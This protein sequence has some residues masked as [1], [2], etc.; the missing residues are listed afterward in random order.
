MSDILGLNNKY[1]DALRTWLEPLMPISAR[2]Y[3]CYRAT[4]HGFEMEKFHTKC[5]TN[6]ET[7][8]PTV[9]LVRVGRFVFGGFSDQRWAG[10]YSPLLHERGRVLPYITYS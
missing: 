2:W 6:S 1:H 10:M 9:T 8:G 5:L 4:E 7:I 3:M